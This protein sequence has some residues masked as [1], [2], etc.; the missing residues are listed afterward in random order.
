VKERL[1][2]QTRAN[3][4]SP[5]LDPLGEY[6]EYEHVPI[7]CARDHVSVT[8]TVDSEYRQS[9]R[10]R[11]VGTLEVDGYLLSYAI[12]NGAV[13][14]PLLQTEQTYRIENAQI[15]EYNGNPQLRINDDAT[16]ERTVDSAD[17]MTRSVET[18]A[19]TH[20][21][22]R[23]D[24]EHASDGTDQ[25]PD[26][27]DSQN[28]VQCPLKDCDYTGKPSSVAAHITGKRDGEHD[29]STLPYASASE[30]KRTHQ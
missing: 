8:G 13:D 25:T 21:T 1:D 12:P 10:K 28:S 9:A 23:T 15:G 17:Q 3:F 5:F 27:D 24:G 7:D 2:I 6:V 30:F 14:T 26:A 22:T 20:G 18:T 11:Q 19:V 4:Q 29:W 16:V